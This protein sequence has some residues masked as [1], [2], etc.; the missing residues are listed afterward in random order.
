MKRFSL[1]T[2]LQRPECIFVVNIKVNLKAAEGEADEWICLAQDR[3][4]CRSAAAKP[5]SFI[6]CEEL[7]DWREES[8]CLPSDV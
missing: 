8:M 2:S 4:H 5:P 3:R 7:T 6:K 1:I